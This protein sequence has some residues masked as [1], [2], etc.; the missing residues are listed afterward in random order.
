VTDSAREYPWYQSVQDTGLEQGDILRGFEIA[1]PEAV[2]VAG[3]DEYQVSLHSL[4][5][6][7]MTQT[8]DIEQGKSRSLILCPLIP[9]WEFVAAAK[10]RNENWGSEIR[11][12]LRQGNLPGY[13]LLNDFPESGLSLTVVDFHEVYTAPTTQVRRFV[14]SNPRRLRVC[15]PYREHL[16][17]AFAR[18][19]MRVGLPIPIPREKLKQQP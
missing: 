5:V 4:D 16:A 1:V 14:T 17:Q 15:P 11:E 13:H 10:A 6:V 19:F 18:F 12:K 9:L 7:I 3:I 2:F 8:C